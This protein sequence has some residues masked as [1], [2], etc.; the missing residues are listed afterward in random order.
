MIR[1]I[2][3][4]WQ[5]WMPGLAGCFGLGCC[6]CLLLAAADRGACWGSNTTIA[7]TL[8]EQTI[9]RDA[10]EA[11]YGRFMFGGI[12]LSEAGTGSQNQIKLQGHRQGT[13]WP[14]ENYYT[15]T[16]TSISVGSGVTAVEHLFPFGPPCPMP[17]D[18]TSWNQTYVYSATIW[19][20]FRYISASDTLTVINEFYGGLGMSP[21]VDETL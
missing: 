11:G 8:Y 10:W 6:L 4:A 17:D 13:L 14:D 15:M 5:R 1:N 16:T 19:A 20:G 18:I 21:I 7:L 3:C 2:V 9:Y 12:T